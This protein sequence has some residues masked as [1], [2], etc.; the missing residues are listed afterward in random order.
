V[1]DVDAHVV[2]NTTIR[3]FAARSD[4]DD[5]EAWE[6]MCECGRPD[7]TEHVSLRLRAYDNLREH[8]RPILADGHPVARARQA[9]QEARATQADAAAL[10]AQARH[11]AG[12]ARRNLPSR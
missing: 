4:P 10:R 12:R 5:R 8:G 7:C 6:F 3:E 1:H 11:Q 9:R 2:V